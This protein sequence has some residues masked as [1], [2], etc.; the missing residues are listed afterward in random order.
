MKWLPPPSARFGASAPVLVPVAEIDAPRWYTSGPSSETTKIRI[1]ASSS[2]VSAY[3]IHIEPSPSAAAVEC[4]TNEYARAAPS[5]AAPGG[6][7]QLPFD[8]RRTALVIAPSDHSGHTTASPSA[9]ATG[10]G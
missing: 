7:T 5:T 6:G 8:T 1:G 3:A 2:V 9:P 4:G 10:V